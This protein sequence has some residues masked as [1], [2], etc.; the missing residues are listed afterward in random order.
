MAGNKTRDGLKISK[1]VRA[2]SGLSGVEIRSGTNHPHIA[3]SSGLRPCP[4]ASSTDAR[5]MVVPWL[6]NI[7]D[8]EP[9]E[10]Y[11]SL[12]S[13]KWGSYS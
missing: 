1:I 6:Q 11:N 2:L 13:G 9:K 5:R 12:R 4:I 3:M 7:V 8:L 10:I